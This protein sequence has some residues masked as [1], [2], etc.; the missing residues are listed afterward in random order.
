MLFDLNKN[1]WLNTEDLQTFR[2]GVVSL[3]GDEIQ[4]NDLSL[5]IRAL[6]GEDVVVSNDVVDRMVAVLSCKGDAGDRVSQ[7]IITI[8]AINMWG[9]GERV[10]HRPNFQEAFFHFTDSCFGGASVYRNEHP[11]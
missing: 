11:K 4:E 6:G 3:A 10:K 8:S 2:D 5:V 1:G 7:I 9:A